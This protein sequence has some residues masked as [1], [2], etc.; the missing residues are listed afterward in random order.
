MQ[1][2]M[3]EQFRVL[4][5]TAEEL[6]RGPLGEAGERRPGED[7]EAPTSRRPIECRTLY[8]SGSSSNQLRRQS[9]GGAVGAAPS[10]TTVPP[11]EPQARPGTLVMA[12]IPKFGGDS[13]KGFVWIK[14]LVSWASIT[15]CRPNVTM[16]HSITTCKSG[17]WTLFTPPSFA[18]YFSVRVS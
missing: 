7:L 6:E 9:G 8:L 10:S 2:R 5:A 12:N 11:S 13:S 3:D 14:L 17:G 16:P 15:V 4:Q 18:D 1:A